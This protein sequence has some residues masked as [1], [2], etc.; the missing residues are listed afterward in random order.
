MIVKRYIDHFQWGCV[1]LKK[2]KN[3][4][5]LKMIQNTEIFIWNYTRNTSAFELFHLSTKVYIGKYQGPYTNNI[6]FF[7]NFNPLPPNVAIFTE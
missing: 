6:V 2:L 4:A 5:L 1:I 3:I 7:E